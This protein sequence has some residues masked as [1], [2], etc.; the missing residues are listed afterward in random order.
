MAL[1]PLELAR[2][3]MGLALAAGLGALARRA[4]TGPGFWASLLAPRL[5]YGLAG[6]VC[7]YTFLPALQQPFAE[8]VLLALVFCGGW[9]GLVAGCSFEL[10]QWRSQQLGGLL[11]EGGQACMAVILVLLVVY[12]VGLFPQ[13]GTIYLS[14]AA[15]EVVCGICMVG[16]SSAGSE[17]PRRPPVAALG[18]ALLAALGIS[19]LQAV[20]FQIAAP[21][22]AAARW[23]A[24]DTTAGELFWASVLG[25]ATGLVGDLSTR[26]ELGS[27]TVC[28]LLAGALL[29]GGGLAAALGLEPLWVGLLAGIWLIN[30][31]L[32]RLDVLRAV[33]QGHDLVQIGLLFGCGW[34]LGMGLEEGEMS[35]GVFAWVLVLVVGLRLAARLGNRLSGQYQQTRGAARHA[36][37]RAAQLLELD[38]VGL[39]LAAS[40]MRALPLEAGTAVLGAVAAGQFGMRL[41]GWWGRARAAV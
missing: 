34:L 8:V 22:E 41:I 21:F 11:L 2:F 24:V 35:M 9:M 32:R 20:S 33:E 29:L 16:I 39:A 19:Q 40:L 13:A 3:S 15:L 7:G 38:D 31:T 28:F 36:S 30:S 5:H 10:R 27:G 26:D 25:C 1:E 18:G 17:R 6:V 37:P 23:I 14:G 4:P 12:L